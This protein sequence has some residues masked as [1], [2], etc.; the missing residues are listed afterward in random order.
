[1][2]AG[3]WGSQ[4]REQ[5]SYH[6]PQGS[7]PRTDLPASTT[8]KERKMGMNKVLQRDRLYERQKGKCCWCGRQMLKRWIQV[9]GLPVPDDLA[10]L[11]H[12]DSKMSPDR[13]YRQGEIRHAVACRACN[14]QRGAA[15]EKGEV[16]M[17]MTKEEAA[18]ERMVYR[19]ALGIERGAR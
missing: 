14:L 6:P 15:E 18:F 16:F 1:M 8:N 19:R 7:D 5:R 12:L 13:G 11:E 2:L 10:T 3:R 17:D 9:D 4:F